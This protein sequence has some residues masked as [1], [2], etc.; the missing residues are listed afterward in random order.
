MRP[1]VIVT[2]GAAMSLAALAPFDR[3][4]DFLR[5]G[6]ER[7]RQSHRERGGIEI[8]GPPIGSPPAIPVLERGQAGPGALGCVAL[9]DG[10]KRE[11]SGGGHLGMGGLPAI[12]RDLRRQMH[13]GADC[14][15]VA[16][17]REPAIGALLGEQPCRTCSDRVRCFGTGTGE[18]CQRIG[19]GITVVRNAPVIA[20]A[21]GRLLACQQRFE[22]RMCGV[23]RT[24]VR[25]RA[26]DVRGRPVDR[27]SG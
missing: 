6:A 7:S 8:V 20:P 12:K 22:R 1:A 15:P 27:R 2:P 19:S 18:E 5:S 4:A 24:N 21:A 26:R 14:P 3:A 16:I 11:A 13:E 10:G 9:S 17:G 25:Q 23:S